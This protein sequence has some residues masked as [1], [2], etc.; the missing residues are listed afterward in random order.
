MNKEMIKDYKKLYQK[1]ADGTISEADYNK[2]LIR[3]RKK[4][5]TLELIDRNS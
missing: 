5:N 2:E 3:L 4:H 1:W